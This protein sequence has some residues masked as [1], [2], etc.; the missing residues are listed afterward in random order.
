MNRSSAV[1]PAVFRFDDQLIDEAVC[2]LQPNKLTVDNLTVEWLRSRIVQLETSMKECQAKKQSL[3]E[4]VDEKSTTTFNSSCSI[5][6]I[7]S[8]PLNENEG[9]ELN[10]FYKLF[11]LALQIK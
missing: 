6:G 8:N 7:K 4:N 3:N 1:L 11:F 10:R 9:L 2:K 5:N